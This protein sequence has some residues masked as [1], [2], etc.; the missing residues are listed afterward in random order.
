MPILNSIL[1][2]W[3]KKRIHQIELFIK[4][5]Y[6][7]QNDWLMRLVAAAK[8]TEFGQQYDFNSIQSLKT[9][10]ERVPVC[11]YDTF[12]EYIERMMRGEK[13]VTWAGDIKWFAKSS[14]TA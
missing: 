11:N 2:W 13:N 3:M 5:P 6:E 8:N 9:F 10:K 4:Y 7:V 12:K 14:G 1:S